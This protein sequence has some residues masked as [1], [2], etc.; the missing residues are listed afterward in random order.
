MWRLV[1]HNNSY[2]QMEELVGCGMTILT[3]FG[4]LIVALLIFAFLSD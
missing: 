4:V 1:K 2:D 3:I